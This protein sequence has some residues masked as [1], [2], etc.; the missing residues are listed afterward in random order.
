MGV[1]MLG[2]VACNGEEPRKPAA[3]GSP[4]EQQAPTADKLTVYY[5][6]TSYR[7]WSCNQ[8]EKLTK[9][10][11]AED[12]AGDTAQGRI[13]LKV[14][15]VEEEAGRHYVDD[16]R[17]V[18]KSVVLSLSSKGSQTEWVNLDKIWGL[19]RDSEKFKKYIA[20]SIHT[21]LKKVS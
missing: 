1:C 8:F 6:H 18:T 19:V 17:L 7:C 20:D 5:F 13:E 3:S 4:A 12:F 16:Y 2:V 21:Y 14:V 9:E 15:N 10:V 11:L